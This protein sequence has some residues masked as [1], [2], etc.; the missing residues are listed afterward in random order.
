MPDHRVFRP[1]AMV[2]IQIRLEDFEE[3]SDP[4]V[5][6]EQVPFAQELKFLQE[7]ETSLNQAIAEARASGDRTG[8]SDLVKEQKFVQGKIAA[9][10]TQSQKARAVDEGAGDLYSIDL[11]T[12][13]MKADWTLSSFKSADTLSVTIPF[14]DAPLESQN[15]R[16]ALVEFYVGMIPVSDFTSPSRWRLALQRRNLLIRGYAYTWSTIHGDDDAVVNIKVR[17][18]IAVLMDTKIDPR[19]PEFKV[20]GNGELITAYVNRVLA[21]IPATGGQKGGD[22]MQSIFYRSENAEEPKLGRLNL[23]KG[24]QTAA[25]RN[26]AAGP[27]G[28]A[29]DDGG[30][31]SGSVTGGG[32]ARMAPAQAMEMSAWDLIVQACLQVG[33]VPTYDP[34]IEAVGAATM[35]DYLL[36]RPPQ[37]LYDD[38]QQGVRVRGGPPDKFSRTLPDPDA[39]RAGAKVQSQV[40]FMVWGRNLKNFSTDRS[41]GRVKA[42]AVEVISY[43]PDAPPSQ[44]A[45]RA[46]FPLAKRATTVGAKGTGKQE[47]V[48]RRYVYGNRSMA[49]L[50]QIAVALF[51]VMGRPQ[52]SVDVETDDPTSYV[53]PEGTLFHDS[54]PDLLRARHG[55]PIRLVVARQV[56]DPSKGNITLTPLSEVFERRTGELRRFLLEQNER[57]RPSLDPDT[58]SALVDR[59]VARMARSMKNA[60]RTDLFYIN[61]ISGS[62]DADSGWSA[63]LNLM[64]FLEARS[65]PAN[66]GVDDAKVDS[67][68]RM[69]DV[70]KPSEAEVAEE[71]VSRSQGKPL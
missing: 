49:Q 32:T 66:L 30:T 55:T 10:R 53:D 39:A 11:L 42:P 61:S 38:I 56:A 65:L 2:R 68:M 5:Q 1:A 41:L 45:L 51:H 52:L 59:M 9:L 58:R 24:S 46:R 8:A 54:D 63:K 22:A 17:S 62:W 16:S 69:P 4:K 3:A 23:L 19:G 18:L 70:A 13:P 15:I 57:F 6:T 7:D 64:N 47:D 33:L 12:V 43:N 26:E 67:K 14:R 35:Q 25:S 40:R 29:E 27:V 20:Q 36:L 21:A 44:R 31:D 34:S 60:N 71:R 28:G 48:V 50:Q 37:T